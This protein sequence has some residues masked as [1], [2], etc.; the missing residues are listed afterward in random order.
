LRPK[1]HG[2]YVLADVLRDQK[3]DFLALCSSLQALV[4]GLGQVDYC[5]ASAVLDAYAQAQWAA[6]NR[7]V[8][9][10]D[11][12]AW[13]QVGMAVNT[14][15]PE[16]MRREREESLQRAILPSEGTTVFGC[17]LGTELPQIAVYAQPFDA[18]VEAARGRRRSTNPVVVAARERRPRHT[19]PPLA[20]PYVAA[21][22][23]ME[24][25]VCEVFEDVL[26]LEA[27]G[28]HDSFFDLGGHSLLAVRLMKG[29]NDALQTQIP[30]AKL[31]EGLTVEFLVS[32]AAPIGNLDSTDSGDPDV[33]E[34]RREKARQQREHQQRRRV[35]LGR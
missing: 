10:I 7:S 2:T 20:N 6:G 14:P 9:S 34:K 35:A 28:I 8:V 17:V 16:D 4:G 18:I 13:Q 1:V 5:A 11:W 19:R 3:L 26:G 12:D 24:R 29:V 33:G 21:R 27:V 32:I 30:V 25:S 31:Y 15:V 23:R 22:T